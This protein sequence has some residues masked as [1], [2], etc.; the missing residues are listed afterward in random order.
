M[1]SSTPLQWS[2]KSLANL[3]TTSA[4]L[5]RYEDAKEFAHNFLILAKQLN[6][7]KL[8]GR[9]YYLLGHV[10]MN[11]VRHAGCSRPIGEESP[12][13]EEIVQDLNQAITYFKRNIMIA[14]DML[15]TSFLYG[16]LGNAY[17]YLGD[18][19]NS[20]DCHR[21][22]L[23]I[24]RSFGDKPAMKKAYINLGNNCVFMTLFDE[25]LVHYKK[26]LEIA[27]EGSNKY[28][29]AQV[30]YY[31]GQTAVFKGDFI[32]AIAAHS[33]HLKLARELGDSA[34]EA[35]ANL[36]LAN[37]FVAQDD[38]PKALYFLIRNYRLS[39]N[40]GDH[41]L[42]NSVTKQISDVVQL[43]PA[44]VVHNEE[45]IVD[46]SYDPDLGANSSPDGVSNV[47]IADFQST[48][49]LSPTQVSSAGSQGSSSSPQV[50][51]MPELRGLILEI[52]RSDIRGTQ[53]T[54]NSFIHETVDPDCGLSRAPLH[55]TLTTEE[56][57]VEGRLEDEEMLDLISRVQ[58]KRIDDQRCDPSILKD[59]TNKKKFSAERQS[60]SINSQRQ[61]DNPDAILDLIMNIQSRRMDE[62]RAELVLPGLQQAA[63]EEI[64]GKLNEATRRGGSRESLIDER[65]YNLILEYQSNRIEDQRST[66]GG[67]TPESNTAAGKPTMPV[68]DITEIVNRQQIG[69]IDSQRAN[70]PTPTKRVE[71]PDSSANI[72]S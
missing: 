14:E 20:Y 66:L 32:T 19:K 50:E 45:I 25:A 13:K 56:D 65:L 43:N 16:N 63:R 57:S 4:A 27:Q 69:R 23:K 31:I 44:A 7:K 1:P 70:P 12:L 36:N 3:A 15:N 33:R 18:F 17:Y 42:Q 22:R 67:G 30:E 2:S 58:S 54:N 5:H 60:D 8:E 11:K 49:S 34:G 37:D 59:S 40:M 28:D 29:E 61:H 53:K 9:A 48:S 64:L 35:R 72:K 41:S 52:A 71:T 62:Q 26:A 6:D 39:I 24:S 10:L 38:L 46:P 21:K 47:N 51:I 55:P 68:D